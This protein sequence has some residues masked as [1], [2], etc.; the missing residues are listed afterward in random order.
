MAVIEADPAGDIDPYIHSNQD[1]VDKLD[2]KYSLEYAKLG[3]SFVTELAL[4][5]AESAPTADYKY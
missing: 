4:Y 1:T 3:L 2:F 5:T